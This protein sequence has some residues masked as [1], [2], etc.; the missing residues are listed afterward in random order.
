[1]KGKASVTKK[2]KRK[3]Q[4]RVKTSLQAGTWD[5]DTV[6]DWVYDPEEFSTAM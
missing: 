4:M 3:K 2:N 6:D 5:E 1:M